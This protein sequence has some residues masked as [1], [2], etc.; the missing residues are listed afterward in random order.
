MKKI[1]ALVLS[2]VMVLVAV[3]AMA[4]DSKKVTDTQNAQT[5]VEPAV[6]V[7]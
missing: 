3:S 7:F 1:L 6:E 4:V 5:A 2:L